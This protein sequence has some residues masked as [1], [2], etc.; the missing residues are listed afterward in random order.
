MKKFKLLA[1]TS[2]LLL[3]GISSTLIESRKATSNIEISQAVKKDLSIKKAIEYRKSFSFELFNND[4]TK[5]SWASINTS[6]NGGALI[7]DELTGVSFNVVSSSTSGFQYSQE[8][9]G[10]NCI[11]TGGSTSSSR[12]MSFTIPSGSTAKLMIEATSDSD[13]KTIFIDKSMTSSVNSTY[14]SL[15]LTKNEMNDFISKEL[16]AGSYYLN[17]TG[18]VYFNKI[19]VELTGMN[20]VSFFDD[21]DTLIKS[22]GV[23]TGET[24]E[25]LVTKD[26]IGQKFSHWSLT[27]GGEAFDFE[28]TIASDISLYA[29][30]ERCEVHTVTFNFNYSGAESVKQLVNDQSKATKIETPKRLGYKFETW[31]YNNATFNF[32]TLITEDITLFAKW[33]LDSV[34]TISGPDSLRFG[35]NSATEIEAILLQY[36]ATDVEDDTCDIEL[37]SDTY[38]LNANEIGEYEIVLSATDSSGNKTTKTIPVEVYDN[39]A[40]IFEGPSFI[41]KSTSIALTTNDLLSEIKATDAIDG[42]VEIEVTSDSYTGFANKVGEYALN[43]LAKDSSGNRR[44]FNLNVVVSDKIPDVWYVHENTIKVQ[45]NIHLSSDKVVNL[46]IQTGELKSGYSSIDVVSNYIFKPTE[47][48]VEAIENDVGIYSITVKARYYSGEEITL[49]RAI[50]VYDSQEATQIRDNALIQSGKWLYNSVI[51]NVSNFF[52]RVYNDIVKLIGHEEWQASYVKGLEIY[53]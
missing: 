26:K 31:Y 29:V 21:D 49:T 52:I 25:A 4:D 37:V 30:Y 7:K 50:K 28:T 40:P 34:P 39:V 53:E 47:E 17:F 18:T 41:Y 12:N 35:Y 15:V 1:L 13:S 24:A 20:E 8:I 14:G 19:V 32:N 48:G 36:S 6:T 51:K 3:T 38:S 2:T 44:T 42:E 43:L 11:R 9:Q 5:P 22:I 23:K 10:L 27:P 16:T 45:K 33:T 46:L